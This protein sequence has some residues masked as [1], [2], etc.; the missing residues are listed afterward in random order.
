MR[1]TNESVLERVICCIKYDKEKYDQIMKRY[2]RHVFSY[3]AREG[4]FY[5][6]D[7]FYKGGD[8]FKE[9]PD[10]MNRNFVDHGMLHRKVRRIDCIQLFLVYYNFL[11]FEEQL[12]A[13]DRKEL[14]K[15]E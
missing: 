4:L 8:D 13:R 3:L 9:Q 1:R 6:L 11:T 14:K 2:A 15:I 5:A 10:I 12:T 7:V